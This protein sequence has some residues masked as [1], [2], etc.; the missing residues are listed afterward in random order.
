MKF[1]KYPSTFH[2][3]WSTGNTA[4]DKTLENTDHFIGREVVVTEKMDGGCVTLYRNK[5][6]ARSLDSVNHPSR[7]WVKNFWGQI[8]HKIPQDIR[9]CGENC[10][11]KHSIH[12]TKLP[13]Y[14]LGFNAWK[15]NECL[16]WDLTLEL[17]EF[18]G[19]EHVPI[20]YRGLY[21]EALIRGLEDQMNF[22]KQ[23]G[24][25]VRVVD[26]FT[27][28]DFT[29]SLAKFVREGHVQTDEHWMKQPVVPNL[30]S[31]VK[32]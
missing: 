7:N 3:P 27:L 30:V 24:Y 19:I 8:R 16:S 31:T 14:F 11:A 21:D 23:E 18:L 2:L 4:G 12:Y 5:I 10:Y 6:H 20:L 28:D 22:D 26:S 29:Q 32:F 9:I 13:A 17:F 25:V 15:D 1:E